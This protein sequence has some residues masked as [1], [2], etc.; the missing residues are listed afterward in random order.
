IPALLLRTSSDSIS[1]A[2]RAI[3]AALVTSSVTNVT[4]G[5]AISRPPRTP[6]YT[7]AAP[8]TRA[9]FTSA[10]PIPRL[11]PVIRT[12]LFAI[13]M[14]AL[15]QFH[16]ERGAHAALTCKT[17]APVET[18]RSAAHVRE[19]EARAADRVL[20]SVPS[21]ALLTEIA[22]QCRFSFA[23]GS[24]GEARSASQEGPEC[25][26]SDRQRACEQHQAEALPSMAGQASG[27]LR[28]QR[29]T[30][31]SSSNSSSF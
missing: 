12:D 5:S 10:R 17:G 26:A 27:P 1:C 4:R 22:L 13:F 7:R 23:I 14:A 2:A 15:L 20:I 24:G 28:E 11:A 30:G 31:C 25:G 21:A 16:C 29:R 18:H 6:A 8:R 3:W 9:S 19:V